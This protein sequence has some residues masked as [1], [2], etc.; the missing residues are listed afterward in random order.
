MAASKIKLSQT[1]AET[2]SCTITFEIEFANQEGPQRKKAFDLI[3]Q[4][5]RI[6]LPTT[7]ERE[8]FVAELQRAGR[9]SGLIV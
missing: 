1:S 9:E 4:L 6:A 3:G 5:M 8:C 7:A 2:A